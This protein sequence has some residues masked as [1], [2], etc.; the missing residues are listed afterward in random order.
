[1]F[2]RKPHHP[3]SHQHI[4]SRSL[5]E[6][7]SIRRNKCLL[8]E[9][10]KFISL[11]RYFQKIFEVNNRVMLTVCFV[12]GAVWRLYTFISPIFVLYFIFN[13][14][15]IDKLHKNFTKHLLAKYF[16]THHKQ[17]RKSLFTQS[18]CWM[19][20]RTI[21]ISLSRSS[22]YFDGKLL[23]FSP[24]YSVV[25]S[26]KLTNRLEEEG[27]MKGYL[28]GLHTFSLYSRHCFGVEE[29]AKQARG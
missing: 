24:K 19:I 25:L 11:Y 12:R 10:I 18:V 23:P 6:S 14:N 15:K 27:K 4:M 8:E 2:R 28:E 22:E 7:L 26:C 9:A 13:G 20:L 5:S 17:N 21:L 16:Q 3:L 29:D 1:M